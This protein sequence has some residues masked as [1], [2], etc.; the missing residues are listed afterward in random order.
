RCGRRARAAEGE[1]PP[2]PLDRGHA[3]DGRR[4]PP[5]R[6]RTGGRV[7]ALE[8]LAGHAPARLVLVL[9]PG[10]RDELLGARDL[11][12][13]HQPGRARTRARLAEGGGV[14]P[15]PQTSFHVYEPTQNIVFLTFPRVHLETKAQI[16]EHFDR[17]VAFWKANCRNR[18]VYYV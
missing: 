7:R 12:R 14:M 9:P 5:R 10:R 11:G 13:R 18:K 16:R 1:Q 3:A 8:G 4:P 6:A 2:R 15:P 17:V